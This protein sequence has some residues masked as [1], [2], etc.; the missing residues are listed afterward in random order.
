KLQTNLSRHEVRV[1]RIL[2]GKKPWAVAAAASLLLA[3]AAMTLGSSMAK[4]AVDNPQ[5]EQAIK[6]ADE[7]LAR[8]SSLKTEN[9]E[10]KKQIDES[11]K[12]IDRIGAGVKERFQWQLLMRYIDLA[13]PQP[14]GAKLTTRAE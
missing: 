12:A 11:Y 9:S 4:S 10:I 8:S 3:I 13:L 6:K 14:D 1:E 2:R 5:V 7:V